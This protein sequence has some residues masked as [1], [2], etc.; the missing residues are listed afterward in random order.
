MH[1]TESREPRALH[2]PQA[3]AGVALGAALAFAALLPLALGAPRAW[4]LAAADALARAVT[5]AVREALD[6]LSTLHAPRFVLAWT[7]LAALGIAVRRRDA[8]GAALLVAAVIGGSAVNHVVKHAVERARPHA[9]ALASLAGDHSFPS[10]HVA[11]AT[12]L[13]GALALLVALG[14]RRRA[15]VLAA[16][17]GAAVIVAAVGVAR[18]ALGRHYPSDVLAAVVLGVGWLALCGAALARYLLRG[19]RRMLQA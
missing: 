19:T 3:W 11:S 6:A 7:A 1:R 14:A 5:P 8:G 15:T 16:G 2:R 18:V 12:L 10:G 4:D 13:W 17:A 9:D